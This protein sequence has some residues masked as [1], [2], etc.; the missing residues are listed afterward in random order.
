[1]PDNVV[2]ESIENDLG[3]ILDLSKLK[4]VKSTFQAAKGPVEKAV[5]KAAS[6]IIE[7]SEAGTTD[8][9]NVTE[10]LK[11]IQWIDEVNEDT[12]NDAGA[13]LETHGQSMLSNH[14]A[15]II[16]PDTSQD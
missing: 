5:F 15:Y 14:H 2:K 10:W 8:R 13:P 7:Q 6:I 1:V 12:E 4:L 11:D 16:V 9:R 3:S